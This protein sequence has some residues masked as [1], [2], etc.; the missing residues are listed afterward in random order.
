[1]LGKFNSLPRQKAEKKRIDLLSNNM[2]GRCKGLDAP[3]M[4]TKDRCQ[5]LTLLWSSSL[6]AGSVTGDAAAAARFRAALAAKEELEHRLETELAA[7]RVQAASYEHRCAHS[8][9][10][11]FFPVLD[12][13]KRCL[14]RAA[15][16]KVPGRDRGRMTRGGR[17]SYVR[18]CTHDFATCL[19]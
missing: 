15:S 4:A 8:P 14:M 9:S 11:L 18:G 19:V 1:M 5:S 6:Q 16:Q 17:W 10:L 3:H 2:K 7:A 13:H 12:M